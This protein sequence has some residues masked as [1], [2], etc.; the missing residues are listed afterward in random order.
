MKI[1]R[2]RVSPGQLSDEWHVRISW[3]PVWEAST[4]EEERHETEP[5]SLVI[6]WSLWWK[7]LRLVR[8]ADLL[9]SRLPI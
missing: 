6:F 9:L 5:P 3:L 8:F 1:G 2:L 4:D 7:T